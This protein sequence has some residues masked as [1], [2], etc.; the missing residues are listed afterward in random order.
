[1]S[2]KCLPVSTSSGW[3]H[4][5]QRMRKV[6]VRLAGAGWELRFRLEARNS[7]KLTAAKPPAINS[8]W[9]TDALLDSSSV[10]ADV[11]TSECREPLA[12]SPGKIS[13]CHTDRFGRPDMSRDGS[14]ARRASRQGCHLDVWQWLPGRRRPGCVP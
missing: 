4:D 1:G 11:A 13:Q 5:W 2:A 3:P 10:L 9:I 14:P 7:P 6:V 8:H 12:N